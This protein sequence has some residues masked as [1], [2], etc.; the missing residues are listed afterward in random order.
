VHTRVSLKAGTPEE[1]SK[2]T[3]AIPETFDLPFQGIVNLIKAGANFHIAAMTAD[4]RIVTKQER[5]SLLK[6][7]S[8]IHPAL[9]ENI[10]GEVVDP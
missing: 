2:R 4:P 3:G 5:R 8:S 1:F 10:E 9:A 6:K 7:L